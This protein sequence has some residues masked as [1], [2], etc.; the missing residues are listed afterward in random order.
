MCVNAS[1]ALSCRHDSPVKDA[2][3]LNARKTDMISETFNV[4]SEIRKTIQNG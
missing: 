2:L 4:L 3:N 1:C